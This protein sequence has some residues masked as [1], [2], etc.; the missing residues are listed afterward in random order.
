[1]LWVCFHPPVSQCRVVK[2]KSRKE[3]CGK[4][5][6]RG[7]LQELCEA[8]RASRERY[9]EEYGKLWEWK[10]NLVPNVEEERHRPR[11]HRKSLKRRR[12]SKSRSRSPP[13]GRSRRPR[14]RRR[15]LQGRRR[16]RDGGRGRDRDR[17]MAWE[18]SHEHEDRDRNYGR[19]YDRD[20][21]RGWEH[22]RG[23]GGHP[24]ANCPMALLSHWGCSP[25][26]AAPIPD[27][28]KIGAACALPVGWPSLTSDVDRGLDAPADTPAAPETV[29]R[30]PS[31]RAPP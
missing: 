25:Q 1:M 6:E 5:G 21:P 14:S 12:G 27:V 2:Y 17:G 22:D 24:D 8:T 3:L 11:E 20:L 23:R 26:P 15:D 30:E 29:R 28:A 9:V 4:C 16:S 10:V 13:S 7:H 18:K 31:V 19:E